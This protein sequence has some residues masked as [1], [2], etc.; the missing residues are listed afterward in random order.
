MLPVDFCL[1][2]SRHSDFFFENEAPLNYQFL[3]DDRNYN[4][5]PLLSNR[6]HAFHA[7]ADGPSFDLDH[8]ARQGLFYVMFLFPSPG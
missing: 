5:V 2:Y 4:R 6:G 7:L 1:L 3:F 8:F